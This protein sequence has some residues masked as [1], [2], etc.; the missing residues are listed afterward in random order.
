MSN[1]WDG[2]LGLSD[3]PA[4]LDRRTAFE[5]TATGGMALAMTMFGGLLDGAG[6]SAA[7]QQRP[8]DVGQLWAAGRIRRVVTGH[9][10]KD[11]SCVISDEI[12]DLAKPG[13]P[14]GVAAR[15]GPV[16]DFWATSAVEQ[17]GPRAP[18][19]SG[20]FRPST[21]PRLHPEVG[22]NKV[23]FGVLS[24]SKDPM[25]NRTNGLGL[26][27]TSTIDYMLI[28]TNSVV[29]VLEEDE[30]RINAGDLLIHR[31]SNHAWR[32]DSK[33]PTYFF[34]FLA[35]IGDDKTP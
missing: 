30:V 20:T 34:Q 18:G 3:A 26:H 15:P 32:N 14:V 25:P 33:L 10:A 24:P 11:R 19:E 22:G 2:I 16:V 28:L 21:S 6:V 8:S 29:A 12:I 5:L 13:N 27:R 9:N 7:A 4:T 17:L 1:R 35:R 31:N 23:M